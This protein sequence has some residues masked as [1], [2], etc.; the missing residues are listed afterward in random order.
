MA[1]ILV[2]DWIFMTPSQQI[3]KLKAEIKFLN[4]CIYDQANV[5][6]LLV[7]CLI[8]MSQVTKK[9]RN[10]ISKKLSNKGAQ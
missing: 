1:W 5:N 10:V 6:K 4:R 8:K 2:T 9:R 7:A 3:K